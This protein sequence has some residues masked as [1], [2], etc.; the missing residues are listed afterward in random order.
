MKSLLSLSPSHPW[1]CSGQG[2]SFRSNFVSVSEK[3]LGSNGG[4][5]AA[6]SWG[7]EVPGSGTVPARW[8]LFLSLRPQVIREQLGKVQFKTTEVCAAAQFAKTQQGVWCGG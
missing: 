5:S 2:A 7:E 1:L 6:V 3:L 8:L 4:A